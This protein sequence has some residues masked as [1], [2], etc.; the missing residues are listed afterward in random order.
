MS[1]FD[2]ILTWVENGLAGLTLAA[3][4][5]IAI[6]GV[7]LRYVFNYIIF[8]SEEAVI[9]LIIYSTFIGAVITLRH[10][11]HVGVDVLSL[12]FKERGKWVLAVLKSLLVAVYCAIM[13]GFGWLMITEPAA[14]NVLTPA[15]KLPI[16]IDELALPIGFSLMFLRAL[17]ILYRTARH[18]QAFPE[19]EE[20]DYGEETGQ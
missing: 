20:E 12:A 18:Q 16:W 4:A 7:I 15:L 11:E 9:F 10:N 2:Q 19:A 17:E 8:W 5:I 14:Q 3:A 13:G 1:R 6:I